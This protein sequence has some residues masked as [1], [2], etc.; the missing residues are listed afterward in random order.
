M[1]ASGEIFVAIDNTSRE[2][3]EATLGR[4]VLTHEL[5]YFGRLRLELLE[6]AKRHHRVRA[7]DHIRPLRGRLASK[8]A[9]KA[10]PE[11]RMPFWP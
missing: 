1:A 7:R 6:D 9:S 5:S 4:L 2:A 8:V 3:A 10:A 11:V